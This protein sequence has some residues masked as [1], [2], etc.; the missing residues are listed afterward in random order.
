MNIKSFV[1]L[2]ALL[3]AACGDKTGEPQKKN[4]RHYDEKTL[5]MGDRVFHTHCAECHGYNGEGKPGWEQPGPDGKL[6]PPPLDNNGRSW[7]L[8]G[9][10]IQQFILHGSPDGRGNMPAWKG[11]LT[12][13]E[14]AAVSAWITSLWSDQVYL[15]WQT[16]AEHSTQ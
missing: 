15:D 6:L 9:M 2:S 10:Q 3:L 16:K 7:R 5:S 13:Q 8:S 12:E 11:K 4:A 1:L 14:I